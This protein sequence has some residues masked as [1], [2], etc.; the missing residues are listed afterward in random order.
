MGKKC[1]FKKCKKKLI[2][3]NLECKYCEKRFC[4]GHRLPEEH[5]CD[6]LSEIHK[7]E[8]EKICKKLKDEECIPKKII[9]I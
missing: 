2:L 9:K 5:K 3:S 7:Q 1:N 4:S 8:N 6:K